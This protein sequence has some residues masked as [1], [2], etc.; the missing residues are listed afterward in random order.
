VRLIDH[1][2]VEARRSPLDAL[3]EDPD[4]ELP[5]HT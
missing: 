4:A 1:A 2:L 3:L 5:T